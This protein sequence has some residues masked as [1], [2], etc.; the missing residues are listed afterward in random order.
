MKE[1]FDNITLYNADC[2]DILQDLP[3]KS[4]DLAIVDPPYGIG[5]GNILKNKSR[6]VIAR[7]KDYKP[8]SGKDVKA[9]D[10]SYFAELFRVSRNQIIWGANH[11]ISRIPIDS[12]AGLF[13]IRKTERMILQ[14]A[15]SPGHPFHRR[16]VFSDF[17]GRA[18][19]KV[20]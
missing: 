6:G 11:F 10:E 1:Q 7:S 8:F 12:R 20:I 14:I 17:G 15:N 16:F 18:C 13:G 5:E 9:P 4:F 2:M 19:F 3:D